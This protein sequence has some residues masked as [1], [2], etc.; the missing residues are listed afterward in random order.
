MKQ[1]QLTLETNTPLFLG[2]ANA[3]G[4]PELRA[5]PFR[6]Q[7][8]YWWRALVGARQ[9]LKP[10]ELLKEE[11]FLLGSTEASSP[12]TLRVAMLP[13]RAMQIDRRYMLPHKV[14]ADQYNM[15]FRDDSS[16]PAIVEN[17]SF[18]LSLVLRPGLQEFPLDVLQ[19]LVLWLHLGGI[20]KRARR[21]FG[22]LRVSGCRAEGIE[23]P[24]SILPHLEPALPADGQALADSVH[25]LLQVTLGSKIIAST[26]PIP[27]GGSKQPPSDYPR[28]EG[29]RWIVLV[30]RNAFRLQQSPFQLYETAMR[31]FWT[32]HLRRRDRPGQPGLLH[33][34]AYGWAKGTKR[35]ASPFHLHLAYSQQGL[36]LVFTAFNAEP[37]P[38]RNTRDS[39]VW[40]TRL[41]ESCRA[42]YKGVHFS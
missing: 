21:G 38:C 35:R 27:S 22:S 28:F 8:H 24:E 13:G 1:L 16:T 6:G 15:R 20:G 19:A 32:N 23:I 37:D 41:L 2:G 39:W 33:P 14:P 3:R 25:S 4:D 11:G 12:V 30:C 26:A 36:H 5:A 10:R 31:D 34:D 9:S 29:G 7:L 40:V 18:N 42:S 17:Q